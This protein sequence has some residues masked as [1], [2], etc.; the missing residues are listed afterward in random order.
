MLLTLQAMNWDNLPAGLL[1]THAR[2]EA[3]RLACRDRLTLLGDPE[4]SDVPVARLMSEDYARE[5]ADRIM[6]AVKDGKPLAHAFTPRPHTGTIHL[7]T[8]D[9][10]GN[11]AALTLT[12]GNTFGACVTVDGLGLPIK[13]S[14]AASRLHTEGDTTLAVE[15]SWPAEETNALRNLGYTFTTSGSATMSAVALENGELHQARR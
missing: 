13:E 14:I 12:H 1:K 2:I 8:A 6:A 5:S 7:S 10:H 4:F 11:F 9:R 15:K 3:M